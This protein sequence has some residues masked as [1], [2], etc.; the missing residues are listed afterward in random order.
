MFAEADI[1][2]LSQKGFN[3]AEIARVMGCSRQ[4]VWRVQASHKRVKKHKLK[5]KASD[6]MRCWERHFR[7]VRFLHICPDFFL[8]LARAAHW[9]ARFWGALSADREKLRKSVFSGLNYTENPKFIST[10]S[11][12]VLRGKHQSF[13]PG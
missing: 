9:G 4:T 8:H 11:K 13:R 10:K 12:L 2:A 3:A 5:V 6:R 1:R 7:K